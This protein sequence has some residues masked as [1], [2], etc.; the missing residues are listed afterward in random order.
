MICK[1]ILFI[2]FLNEPDLFFY[3]VKRFQA[4]H[5]TRII[6][7]AINHMFTHGE[8]VTDIAN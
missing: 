4:F 8:V 1:N 5:L 2:T 6:L 3:T 7:F